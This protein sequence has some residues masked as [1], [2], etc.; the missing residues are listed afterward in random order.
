MPSNFHVNIAYVLSAMFCAEP[1][2]L[3][4]MKGDYLVPEP[5]MAFVNIEEAGK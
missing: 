4:T 1:D 3:A 2:Q 5:M